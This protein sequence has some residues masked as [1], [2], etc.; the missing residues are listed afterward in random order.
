MIVL[1]IKTAPKTGVFSAPNA[2][3]ALIS[4][5]KHSTLVQ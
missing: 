4:P 3:V 5:A 1:G 2:S